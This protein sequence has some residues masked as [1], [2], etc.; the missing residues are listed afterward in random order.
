MNVRKINPE[1]IAREHFTHTRVIDHQEE[2]LALIQ[3]LFKAVILSHCERHTVGIVIKLDSGEIIETFCDLIDF[4]DD[5][6]MIK[7]GTPI[8]V[9]AIVDVEF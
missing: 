2:R 6:I 8:P 3:K 4:A 1:N 5:H 7:G 9:R